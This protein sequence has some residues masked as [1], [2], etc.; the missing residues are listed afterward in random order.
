MGS[1]GDIL[2][3]FDIKALLEKLLGAGSATQQQPGQGQETPA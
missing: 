1:L 3:D 2:G